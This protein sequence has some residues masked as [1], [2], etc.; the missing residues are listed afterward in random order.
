MTFL[1]KTHTK[2]VTLVAKTMERYNYVEIFFFE[3]VGF[4]NALMSTKN[5]ILRDVSAHTKKSDS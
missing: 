4:F 5:L 3:F 1:Y 2:F